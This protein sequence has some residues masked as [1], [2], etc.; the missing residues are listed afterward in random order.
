MK[1]FNKLKHRYKETMLWMGVLNSPFK[2]FKLKFYM[3]KVAVGVPYFL[4]RKWVK[5]TEK[6]IQRCNC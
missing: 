4:P 5:F 1:I 6:D 2:A 3:G